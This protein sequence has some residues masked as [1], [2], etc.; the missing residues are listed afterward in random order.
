[1]PEQVS[2]GRTAHVPEATPLISFTNGSRFFDGAGI[3]FSGSPMPEP[4]MQ[5]SDPT[6]Y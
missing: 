6:W 3:F 2:S 5:H 1:M 4:W